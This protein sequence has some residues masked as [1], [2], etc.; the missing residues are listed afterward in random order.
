VKIKTLHNEN[1]EP[2]D[3]SESSLRKTLYPY[4]M[5][6]AP[7][8]RMS[9]AGLDMKPIGKTLLERAEKDSNDSI[10]LMDL[11]IY[12]QCIGQHEL[13][14]AIQQQA[15]QLQNIFHLPAKHQPPSLRV[16]AV[17]AAGDLSVNMP[18]ECLLE[19]T[20]VDLHLFYVTPQSIKDSVIPEHDVLLVAVGESD[21]NH[22]LLDLLEPVLSNWPRPVLNDPEA[23]SRV[24][25]DTACKLMQGIP[26]LLM[27]ETFRMNRAGMTR[28][29]NANLAST[30]LPGNIGFPMIIRPVG[31]HAGNGL[32][33]IDD[34]RGLANYLANSTTEE[35]FISKFIDYCSSDGQF[36]KFRIALIDG[37]PYAC[38]M[39][40]SSHWMVHYVNAGMYNDASKRSEEEGFMKKFDSFVQHHAGALSEISRR[41]QL[42]Y[43]CLDCSEMQNGDLFIFEI[44]TAMIVHGMDSA[45][46]FPYKEVYMKNVL[47]AFRAL[48]LRMVGMVQ[49]KGSFA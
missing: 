37:V 4:F 41:L 16:I 8:L 26:G 21:A 48:L 44:D 12:M 18:V 28:V 9:I 13:G 31:S 7:F 27:P 19:N 3:K 14:V 42:Q 35:F 30:D 2:D 17:M 11:S 38:H 32:E 36:R 49:K 20:D 15:L 6:L 46:L 29:A 40:I 34:V 47:D 39:A 1:N 23:I 25:R 45:E 10:A 22:M 43:V 24:A 33:K 5:G